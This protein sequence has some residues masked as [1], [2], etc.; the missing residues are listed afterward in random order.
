MRIRTLA[1]SLLLAVPLFAKDVTIDPAYGPASG[2]TRVTLKGDF[3]GFPYGL[4]FGGIGVGA[5]SVER[6]DDHT[7]IA[8]TPPHLPGNAP[9]ALFEY[10]IGI[11]TNAVFQ[12]LA[13][14]PDEFERLL[15]PV[16][17]PPVHGAFGSE[18]HTSLHV[19]GKD[20]GTGV[21]VWGIRT[22]CGI[23]PTCGPWD[24]VN[25]YID[26][27]HRP[28]GFKPEDFVYEGSPGR[29]VYVR[30]SRLSNLAMNLRVAD[31]S[32]ATENFGTE[33][34]IVR[35]DQFQETI[36]LQGVPSD[37]LFRNS[38]WIYA[39]EPG[40]AGIYIN[41]EYVAS[42]TLNGPANLFSPAFATFNDF[43]VSVEPMTVKVIVAQAPICTCVPNKV[44]SW[45]VISVT[46]ND[47]Q[48]FTT[49]TPQT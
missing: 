4:I 16:F 20:N 22:S 14:V 25:Q 45:A 6:V 41:D 31:V 9:V 19:R 44:K 18:F 3:G 47:T 35:Q 15:L 11:G 7:I 39:A 38:L 26:T 32:R 5:N 8:T 34:P 1:V 36:V 17:V 27:G 21:E 24:Y 29:F 23:Y 43:P 40:I 48:Q 33:V 46:N 49:I 37:P 30:K 42:V 2:G 13:P 10:D 12:Y 28:N